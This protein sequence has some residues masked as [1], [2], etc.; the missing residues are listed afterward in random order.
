MRLSRGPLSRSSRWFSLVSAHSCCPCTRSRHA[1]VRPLVS[2]TPAEV[3][4]LVLFVLSTSLDLFFLLASCV[5]SPLSRFFCFGSLLC[6]SVLFSQSS[7]LS[8][9]RLLA[10]FSVDRCAIGV[11]R[12]MLTLT[13]RTID[14]RGET[15]DLVEGDDNEIHLGQRIVR[16]PEE[17]TES[18]VNLG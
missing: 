13:E 3:L 4:G 18:K 16:V 2:R 7:S 5:V 9:N 11:H 17:E 8:L 15:G 6:L 1:C 10:H 14:C 12:A